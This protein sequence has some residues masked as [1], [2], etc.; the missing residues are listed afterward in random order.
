MDLHSLDPP[1]PGRREPL[2]TTRLGRW[3][4][5]LAFG[6]FVLIPMWRLF[7]PLGAFPGLVCELLGGA[8]ALRAMSRREHRDRSLAVRACLVPFAFAVFFIVGSTAGS[9]IAGAG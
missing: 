7:G 9:L 1:N 3:A 2:P 6:G 5:G 4:V 8:L